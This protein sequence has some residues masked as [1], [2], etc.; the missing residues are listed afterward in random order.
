MV[1]G[2]FQL[3]LTDANKYIEKK[4]DYSTGYLLKARAL[5]ALNRV[6]H[7]HQ[8]LQEAIGKDYG[9]FTQEKH[10]ELVSKFK[11]RQQEVAE[12]E[13]EYKIVLPDFYRNWVVANP[14]EKRTIAYF[15]ESM[16]AIEQVLKYIA[17]PVI[18]SLANPAF[19]TRHL[20][21][22]LEHNFKIVEITTTPKKDIERAII[23]KL[24]IYTAQGSGEQ[25]T[26]QKM[27]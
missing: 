22:T 6:D 14:D 9:Y 2:E 19:V 25:S 17:N 20:I 15:F 11:L 8:V 21:N 26:F 24:M 10:D 23:K 3:A 27:I 12:F 1:V 7:A 16:K 5:M 13:L 4:P 18:F